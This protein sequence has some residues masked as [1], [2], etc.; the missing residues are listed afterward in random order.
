M[1]RAIPAVVLLL[2]LSPCLAAS[3]DS[4]TEA[5]Q[6]WD[7][8]DMSSAVIILKNRLDAQPEDVDARLMLARIYLDG[9]LGAAAEKE[10]VRAQGQGA[11]RDATLLPM[12]RALLLQ[13]RLDEVVD[14]VS[15]AAVSG[16][17]RQATLMA[18]RGDAYR[19]RGDRSSAAA[20]YDRALATYPGLAT[21]LLGQARLALADRDVERAGALLREATSKN[22]DSA[23][24]WELSADLL[25]AQGQVSEAIDAFDKAEILSRNKLVPRF[26]RAVAYLD[27][28]KVEEAL[29]DIDLIEQQAPGFPGLHF[30]HGLL[31][32][33]QGLVAR[34]IESLNEY[35]RYDP[36]NLRAI[37]LLALAELGRGN[38]DTG[39][40]LLRRYLD[41]LP[42]SLRA[43]LALAKS[44]LQQN[45]FIAARTSLEP[46]AGDYPESHQLQF[47]LSQALAGAGQPER[48]QEALDRALELDPDN[49]D[50]LVA[51]AQGLLRLGR[52]ED[53]IAAL[54]RAVKLDPLNRT[55]PL[56]RVRIRLQQERW[57]DALSLAQTLVE[58]RPNDPFTLNALGLARLGK[59]DVDGARDALTRAMEIRPDFPDAALNLARIELRQGDTA[60]A[61][62][63]LNSILEQEPG[64]VEAILA[65]AQL[66][67]ADGLGSNARRRLADA[68]EA[69]P[70][71]IRFRLALARALLLDEQ[72][73]QAIA[74]LQTAPDTQT[75]DPGRL[76]LLGEAQVALGA[77]KEAAATYQALLRAAP[78]QAATGH[79]LLSRVYAGLENLPAMEESLVRAVELEPGNPLVRPAL[80]AA[81]KAIRLEQQQRALMDRLVRASDQDPRLIAQKA[82]L[83]VKQ[84]DAA[85]AEVLMQGLWAEYPS[86][87]GVM[88]KLFAIQRSAG[89]TEGYTETLERWHAAAPE[90]NAAQLMLGQIYAEQGRIDEA[91]PLFEALL[92]RQPGNALVLNN[93]AWL[94]RDSDPERALAYAERAHRLLPDDAA[95]TD[96]LGLLLVRAGQLDRGLRLL[97]TARRD[98][99]GNYTIAFH[100]AQALV[101][102]GRHTEARLLLLELAD[103]PFAEQA[104]ARSLLAGLGD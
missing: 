49:A 89:N 76:L 96:T 41:A 87:V 77:L 95:T 100:Y 1:R 80:A 28:G 85:Q 65:L 66:D 79:L 34:G 9:F 31:Y 60:G 52:A 44:Q 48:A 75:D 24:A 91:I 81:L 42:Q 29:P 59:D 97:D 99:P 23:S 67:A 83:L 4:L 21:A 86:D 70:E 3:G 64:H 8:G 54:D 93:L 88:R 22:P 20:E 92:E 17:K 15:P 27:A 19:G 13:G 14:T 32:L 101:K 57:D 55:A 50:Y 47:L 71:Q 11:S 98:A 63:L 69:H 35:L 94:L 2:A 36:G 5:E 82:D 53:A 73:G 37:Y 46:I 90:D 7:R 84:G 45:D 40:V 58:Q 62:D 25:L 103:R 61:R 102:A 6:H 12:T 38:A 39:E 56:L 104:A 74:I 16:A 33:R 43:T 51:S 26:K 78:G 68:V 30:A 18:Y 10:L 72:S